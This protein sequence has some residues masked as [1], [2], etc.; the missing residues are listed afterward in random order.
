MTIGSEL[1]RAKP[2]AAYTWTL[3]EPG[4]RRNE[5]FTTWIWFADVASAQLKVQNC[6]GA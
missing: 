6:V 1:A 4:G 5:P 2:E 3:D